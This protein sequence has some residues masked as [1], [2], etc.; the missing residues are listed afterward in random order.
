[1]LK[2]DHIGLAAR[3][4]RA[5][6]QNLAAILGAAEPTVEGADDDMY[7]IDL[8]HGAF[9]LFNPAATVHPDHVAFRVDETRFAEVVKRLEARGV[10]FG[11]DPE[12]PRNGKT[13]DPLGGA[14][15]VYFVDENGHLF[16][17]TC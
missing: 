5:S 17:V 14:G 4:A 10:A 9:V 16:E 3:D 15:R 12:D 6:A 7:R 8:D 11:N 13:E 2:V 1:M